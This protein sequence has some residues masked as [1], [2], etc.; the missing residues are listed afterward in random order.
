MKIPVK[1]NNSYYYW[2]DT[3]VMHD[4][5]D[6]TCAVLVSNSGSVFT[7]C[8]DKIEV[9]DDDYV[10]EKNVQK[11]IDTLKQENFRLQGQ[12]QLDAKISQLYNTQ[13]WNDEK[14]Y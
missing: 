10:Y 9:V 13:R 4:E 1:Y 8:I 2:V 14:S 3:V 11:R 12:M 7:I 6:Y 5:Y